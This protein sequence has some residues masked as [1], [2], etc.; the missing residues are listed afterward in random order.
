MP[1]PD[2]EATV[3]HSPVDGRKTVR[4]FSPSPSKSA[5]AGRS[6]GSPQLNGRTSALSQKVHS[7]RLMLNTAVSPVAT[8]DHGPGT[9]STPARSEEHTSELQSRFGI[10]Y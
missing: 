2:A 7:P 3:H 10:S 5:A 8:G 1:D 6:P 9:G 4:S